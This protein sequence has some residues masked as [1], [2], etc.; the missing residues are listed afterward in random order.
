MPLK[1]HG[2]R[3]RG[4]L[5]AHLQCGVKRTRGCRILPFYFHDSIFWTTRSAMLP[6]RRCKTQESRQSYAAIRNSQVVSISRDISV[7]K[8]PRP[9]PG[10][11]MLNSLVF[12]AYR[13][14]CIVRLRIASLY[15]MH[16]FMSIFC[17]IF[18]E[19]ICLSSNMIAPVHHGT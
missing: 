9:A 7:S 3:G 15:T 17:I 2:H 10:Q 13:T 1:F 4:T 12:F 16:S 6:H 18:L 11:D 5:T 8:F 14:T 19:Y